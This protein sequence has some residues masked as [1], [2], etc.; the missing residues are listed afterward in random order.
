MDKKEMKEKKDVT[1]KKKSATNQKDNVK[2]NKKVL[3][4]ALIVIVVCI[5]ILL[6]LYILNN[7][8]TEKNQGMLSQ[9]N[10]E[11]KV[12]VSE[13]GRPEYSLIDMNNKENAK[14]AE[15]KKENTSPELLG[16]K[17]FEDLKLSNINLYAKDGM[18]SFEA[19][20]ENMSNK[21]FESKKVVLVFKDQDGKEIRRVNSYLGLI[22]PGEKNTLSAKTSH[23]V[24]NAYDF[25]LEF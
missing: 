23:D 16:E 17:V 6:V 1:S 13:Q 24:V 14:I 9:E 2:V 19:Q 22:K 21:N 8:K 3:I 7:D 18:V 4:I 12:N 25:S 15:G 5:S 10:S 20:V 11:Q